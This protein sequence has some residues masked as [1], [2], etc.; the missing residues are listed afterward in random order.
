MLAD[1]SGEGEHID[2]AEAGGHGTDLPQKPVAEYGDGQL[3]SLVPSRCRS[4]EL[5]HAA[6]ELGEGQQAA[7][8]IEG[9]I[10]LLH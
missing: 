4:P 3:G 2:A 10:Q 5:L 8:A 9:L 1:A 6:A 7:L